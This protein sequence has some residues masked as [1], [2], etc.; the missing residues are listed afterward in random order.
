MSSSS[1]IQRQVALSIALAQNTQTAQP[2]TFAESGTSSVNIQGL[3]TSV[4]IRDSGTVNAT[5]SVRVWGLP[6]SLMNQL[7]TLGLVLNLVPKNIITITA[8]N[9]GGQMSSVFQG[10]IWSAYGEYSGQPDVPF[11]MECLLSGA[12]N[13]LNTPPTSY[14]Q[15]FDVATAFGSI[16]NLMGAGF[17][18]NG[19]SVMLPPMYLSGA[20]MVQARKLAEAANVSWG[21]PSGN[22]LEIWPKNGNRTAQTIPKISAQTGMIGYPAFTQKGIIVK[23]LFNPQIAFG[24]K[25]EVDSVVLSSISQVQAS[26]STPFPTQWAVNK[27]DLDLDAYFPKGQWMSTVYAYAPGTTPPIIPQ[28]NQ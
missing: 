15:Q 3:R 8:G 27:L 28:S 11:V 21:F 5:A 22:I 4:R 23:T 24:S 6:P 18:N 7:S 2:S 13:V 26:R 25:V 17:V 16:A 12:N 14:P 19:V 20:P 1:L 10:T 9:Q